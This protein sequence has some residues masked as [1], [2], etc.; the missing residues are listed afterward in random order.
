MDTPVK[1]AAVPYTMHHGQPHPS[2]SRLFVDYADFRWHCYRSRFHCP[3]SSLSFPRLPLVLVFVWNLLL[4]TKICFNNRICGRQENL[5]WELQQDSLPLF[6]SLCLCTGDFHT[7]F[8]RIFTAFVALCLSLPRFTFNNHNAK[9]FTYNPKLGI[10]FLRLPWQL[11]KF[12]IESEKHFQQNFQLDYIAK[13]SDAICNRNK[14][15]MLQF[16][17]FMQTNSCIHISC[18]PNSQLNPNVENCK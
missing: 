17:V 15:P 4:L 1:R 16:I 5:C 11:L 3:S 2:P 10:T 12:L 9:Y 13:L 8:W 14:F 7:A 18:K 6:F